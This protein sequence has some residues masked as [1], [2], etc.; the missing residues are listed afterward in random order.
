MHWTH[1]DVVPE[2]TLLATFR[3]FA[4]LGLRVQIT[5]M[6]VTASDGSDGLAKQTEAFAMAARV[7]QSVSSCDRMTVW[8]VSDRDSWRGEGNRP[9]LFD[10]D[11]NEKPAYAA[12]RAAL[13]A[14]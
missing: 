2:E 13:A 14:R 4:A 10:G 7:C 11:F 5:E 1:S 8:G 3:R 9:L 12:V 6:D